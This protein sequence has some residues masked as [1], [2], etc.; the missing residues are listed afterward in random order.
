MRASVGLTASSIVARATSS[1]DTMSMRVIGRAVKRRAACATRN[2]QNE[3]GAGRVPSTVWPTTCEGRTTTSGNPSARSRRSVSA[4]A[5][6]YRAV[7]TAP[8]GVSPVQ[9]ARS[10]SSCTTPA[11]AA[12]A[13]AV[14]T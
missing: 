11:P 12:P 7:S 4:F 2:I 8:R 9:G 5:C 3:F 6:R 1:T 10:G 13:N 14:P